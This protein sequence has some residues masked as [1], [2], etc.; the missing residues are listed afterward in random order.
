MVRQ[1]IGER[2][3]EIEEIPDD[4]PRLLI[5]A[6]ATRAGLHVQTIRRYEM[7]GLVKGRRLNQG[8]PLYSEADVAQVD[9][10]RRLTTDLGVN[11]AGAAAVLHLRQ[12]VIELQRELAALQ[13]GGTDR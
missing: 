10:V 1:R 5:A 8:P 9:R 13:Q 11:L 12:Q 7:Y 2:W 4:E 3:I 6:V